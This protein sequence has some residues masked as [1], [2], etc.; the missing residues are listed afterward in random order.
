[1][2]W[3]RLDDTFGNHPKVHQAG[4]AA[5]GL[6]VRCGTY[7]AAYLLDGRVPNKV[8]TEYGTTAEIDACTDAGLWVRNGT[9]FVIPDY[10]DFNPSKEQVLADRAAMAERQRRRRRNV[11]NGQYE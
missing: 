5:V 2:T 4:N 10:L 7:S 3:F 9:G 1:M 6:W 11:S 8:V